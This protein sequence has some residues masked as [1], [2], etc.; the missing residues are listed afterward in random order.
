MR[1]PNVWRKIVKPDRSEPGSSGCGL[2]ASAEL[3][4]VEHDTELGVAED[5]V[6]RG[7]ETRPLVVQLEFVPDALGESRT[8]SRETP[9]RCATC[10]RNAPFLVETP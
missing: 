7:L 1:V 6:G 10:P 9:T 3:C 4:R 2:E 8:S 5:E